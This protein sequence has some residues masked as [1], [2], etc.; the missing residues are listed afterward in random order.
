MWKQVV[1]SPLQHMRHSLVSPCNQLWNSTAERLQRT[2]EWHQG[3]NR[4]WTLK[5]K[6][7]SLEERANKSEE[8]HEAIAAAL[9]LLY[10]EFCPGI[11]RGRQCCL[12]HMNETNVWTE[13]EKMEQ[14]A[15][16][17]PS[18]TNATTGK[19]IMATSPHTCFVISSWKRSKENRN[20]EFK[21]TR[22]ASKSRAGTLQYTY[23]AYSGHRHRT[24]RVWQ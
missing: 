15:L 21:H 2:R 22:N 13:K 10:H 19:S 7:L 8:G 6:G 14:D 5:R 4:L 1:Y 16:Q 24:R 12:A 18:K 9:Q 20:M 23:I 17:E 3:K 11:E